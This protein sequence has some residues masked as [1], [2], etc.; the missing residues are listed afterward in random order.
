MG[1]P[2]ELLVLWGVGFGWEGW[3]P[4]A[5]P[6]FHGGNNQKFFPVR[7]SAMW[8]WRAR[9]RCWQAG[10]M[11]LL[12]ALRSGTTWLPKSGVMSRLEWFH[13]KAAKTPRDKAYKWL[14]AVDSMLQNYGLDLA[15]FL[16]DPDPARRPA[17]QHW[18]VLTISLDQGSTSRSHTSRQLA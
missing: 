2:T 4:T 3:G 12:N 11:Q 8:A 9:R 10:W 5:T 17:A 13:T 16:L 18:P 15:R 14:L 6:G 7:S 1:T